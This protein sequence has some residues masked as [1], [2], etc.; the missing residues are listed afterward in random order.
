[1]RLSVLANEINKLQL[2]EN[3]DSKVYEP[4]NSSS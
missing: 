4:S 1:M 3:N 2:S